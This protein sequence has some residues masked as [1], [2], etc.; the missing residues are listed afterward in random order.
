MNPQNWDY[1]YPEMIPQQKLLEKSPYDKSIM[2]YYGHHKLF[3][4][5]IRCDFSPAF[6]TGQKYIYTGS[7]DGTVICMLKNFSNF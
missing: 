3:K 5:L 7:T 4:T 6:S 1:R 2:T